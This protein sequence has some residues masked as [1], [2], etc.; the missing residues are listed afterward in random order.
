MSVVALCESDP[1]LIADE[2]IAVEFVRC[3]KER[4]VEGAPSTGLRPF[5]Y[6]RDV[7]FGQ[8]VLDP[9]RGVRRP[10]VLP[11]RQPGNSENEN[12]AISNKGE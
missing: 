9:D 1:R 12:L 2:E 11:A 10:F 4:R 7:F 3:S 8:A 5:G 6:A